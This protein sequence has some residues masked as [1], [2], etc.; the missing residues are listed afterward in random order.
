MK[1]KTRSHFYGS[2]W[3]LVFWILFFWPVAIIYYFMRR[4]TTDV[5]ETDK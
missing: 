5:K 1:T 4:E 2:W 3:A